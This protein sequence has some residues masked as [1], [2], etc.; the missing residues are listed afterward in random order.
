M[1][2]TRLDALRRQIE[3]AFDSG[4]P[5]AEDRIGYNPYDWESQE[6][7][8]TFKGRHWKELTPAE[9]HDNSI[10]F[11]SAEGFRYYLP[12]YLM[13][14]LTDYGDLLPHTVYGLMLPEDTLP[15]EESLRPWKLERF[16]GLS[17]EQKHAVRGFLEYARDEFS[18]YFTMGQQPALA[19][20]QYWGRF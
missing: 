20:A 10:S 15:P 19:L 5:P 9:L 6:L 7:T 1:A 13:S 18:M 8:Q 11:T 14:A 17:P 3:S 16:E 2:N 4:P 12:A